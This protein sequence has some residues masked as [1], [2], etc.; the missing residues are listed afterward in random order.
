MVA[1]RDPG[2]FLGAFAHPDGMTA[3][4]VAELV[5]DH[6]L[7]LVDV[8]GAR[9]QPGLDV[10]VLA[11]GDEGVDLVV[12][13]K[14]DLD[15][16]V[17]EVRRPRSAAWRRRGTA[18]PSR[19]REGS[20]GLRRRRRRAAPSRGP[21]PAPASASARGGIA[22]S[23]SARPSHRRAERS[24]KTPPSGGHPNVRCHQPLR[25]GLSP[26]VVRLVI[27]GSRNRRPPRRLRHG[28]FVLGLLG[29]GT[30]APAWPVCSASAAGAST[31]AGSGAGAVSTVSSAFLA[32]VLRRFGGSAVAG[33]GCGSAGASTAAIGGSS[34]IGRSTIGELSAAMRGFVARQSRCA[35]RDDGGVSGRRLGAASSSDGSLGRLLQ[36]PRRGSSASAASARSFAIL[37]AAASAAATTPAAT[38]ASRTVVIR[39]S[40]AALFALPLLP[41]RHPRRAAPQLPRGPLRSELVRDGAAAQ[42]GAGPSSR[43]SSARLRSSRRSRRRSR[44]RSAVRSRRAPTRFLLST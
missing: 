38:A 14:D 28:S 15:A 30:C 21:A 17:V 36:P 37:A 23:S 34:S 16:L 42:S 2:R 25:R 18:F 44:R 31:G 3:G 19:C 39:P 8:V 26:V 13:E 24:M 11:A 22:A 9:D 43:R 35:C 27:V 1:K 29:A 10:D 20:T 6:A 7:K 5:S 33:S 12:L 41:P 4:D 32:R 40:L